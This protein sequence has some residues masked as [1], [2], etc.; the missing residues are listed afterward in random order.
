MALLFAGPVLYNLVTHTEV[1]DPSSPDAVVPD[2]ERIRGLETVFDVARSTRNIV[3]LVVVM[4]KVNQLL[5]VRELVQNATLLWAD[6]CGEAARQ[7][8][9]ARR[10]D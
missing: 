9:P 1:L 5:T 8:E 4:V 10:A 6:R 7:A 3:S 2:V